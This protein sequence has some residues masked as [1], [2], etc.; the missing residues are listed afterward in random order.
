MTIR[1]AELFTQYSGGLVTLPVDKLNPNGPFCEPQGCLERVDQASTNI[2]SGHQSVDH[3]LD[4]VFFCFGELGRARQAHL[5]AVNNRPGISAGLQAR[6][7]V[8]KLAFS[9][10]HHWREDEKLLPVGA[11]HE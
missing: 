8:D 2:G 5:L 3:H 11:G 4:I 1:A 9:L 7:Q 10:V 6:E